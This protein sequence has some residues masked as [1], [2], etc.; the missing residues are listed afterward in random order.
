MRNQTYSKI[1]EK[2]KIA[3]LDPNKT[4]FL[5]I[6]VDNLNAEALQH[7]YKV[8]TEKFEEHGIKNIMFFTPPGVECKFTEVANGQ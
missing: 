3:E 5:Q 4:Y 2:L 6:C 8:L 7:V 1:I